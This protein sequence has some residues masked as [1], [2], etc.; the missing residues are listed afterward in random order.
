MAQGLSAR[1]VVA[2]T[3]AATGAASPTSTAGAGRG[4]V[5][6]PSAGAFCLSGGTPPQTPQTPMPGGRGR[7]GEVNR[8]ARMAGGPVVAGATTA[9]GAAEGG[10]AAAATR[11]AALASAAAAGRSQSSN[12]SS[13]RM[14]NSGGVPPRMP[15]TA[16]PIRPPGGRG[17]GG[18]VNRPAGMSNGPVAAGATTAVG[19][20]EGGAVAEER[21]ATT[22]T[23]AVAAGRGRGR[24]AGINIPAWMANGG[25]GPRAAQAAKGA[26]AEVEAP[27]E[28]KKGRARGGKDHNRPGDKRHRNEGKER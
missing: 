4:Q 26:E 17:R 20:A 3:T 10:T 24:G 12:N 23:S 25:D 27:G 13:A 5:N 8:P 6:G 28:H 14:P 19:A 21:R 1:A 11:A 22:L 9:G 2:R 16:T 15:Q 7:S 18:D